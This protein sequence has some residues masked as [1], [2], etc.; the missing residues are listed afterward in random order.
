MLSVTAGLLASW[1]FLPQLPHLLNGREMTDSS[2]ASSP[3]S[4]TVGLQMASG[5]QRGQEVRAREKGKGILHVNVME[6]ITWP[7]FREGLVW[8]PRCQEP[9]TP[10][11]IV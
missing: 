2:P 10:S 8:D 5:I 4:A 6:G 9:G 7:P 11:I 3:A 1:S